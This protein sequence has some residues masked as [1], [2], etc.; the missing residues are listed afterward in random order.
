MGFANSTPYEIIAAPFS[1]WFAPVGT[2]FPAIDAAPAGPWALV[3]SSGDLNYF[4]EGVTIEIPQKIEFFRALGDS[5]SRKAFRVEEDCMISLVLA[6]LTL[7]QFAH[8]VNQN[9]ITTTPAASGVAGFKKIGLSRGFAVATVALIVRGPS[10]Y[11]DNMTWQ[12]EVARAAQTGN[13]KVVFRRNTPAG[14]DLQWTS[15]VDPTAGS[16]SERIGKIKAQT[17]AA[18][19]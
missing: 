8:A 19:P 6:D 15:L 5:A 2:A 4:D 16:V 11:G 14:L 3:G 9:T 1:A 13:P 10:P 18:L 12:L 17:A 7:E